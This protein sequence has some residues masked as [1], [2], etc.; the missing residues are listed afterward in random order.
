MRHMKSAISLAAAMTVAFAFYGCNGSDDT[1]SFSGNNGTTPPSTTPATPS[2][3]QAEVT[4]KW[5]TGDLHVHTIESDD[6]QNKLVDVLDQAMI[7]NNLDWTAITN[8]LRVSTRDQNGTAIVGGPLPF[9]KA[10]ADYEIP[11]VRQLQVNGSYT[12][13][14]IFSAFEWDMPTHDHM[15]VGI[16]SGTPLATATKAANQFEYYFTDR[17]AA[18]FDAADVASW[19]TSG[20]KGYTTHAD[21][22]RAV[23]WL[24]D[25]FPDTSY[26]LI[27]HPS[28]NSGKYTVA[29]YR[30]FNDTAPKVVFG[31]EGMVGNQM[32]PDR[33]GYTTAYVD[34]NL[35]NR[36]YGGVDY[37]VAQV[38]GIWDALL[39]DGR[40]FWNVGDSD[41]HFKT[42]GTNSSG[43]Y[44][45]EY[46]KTYV[47][48]DNKN[49]GIKGVLEGVR[50]GKMFSV[51]GDLINALD[52]NI[53]SGAGKGEM[54]GELKATAGETVTVTIRFKSPDRNNYQYPING[55]VNVNM[56]PVVD[57]IDLIAGDVTPRAAAGTPEYSKETNDSTKV[58]ATFTSADWKLDKDGYNTVTY[59][60]KAARN[61]YFRLRGTN[62]GMNVAGET[63]N[64]NPLP[65]Q[66]VSVTEA[67]ARFNAINARNY[68]DLWFYSNPVF[69]TVGS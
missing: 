53:A 16:F 15:N 2:T 9:S 12:T 64:G 23:A 25:N 47:W 45:G 20:T 4:G 42:I 21:A 66:K 68:N 1:S 51:F 57:H 39:G 36:V 6:A 22:V 41:H 13:K 30:E 65:D 35:K 56:R 14:L 46:A 61:Q 7:T 18:Q 17:P 10:M 29:D 34:A 44:P 69:V 60:Y 33:G 24:R 58:I 38:G 28:R 63:S 52:F 19:N 32:E 59:T 11:A 5:T 31:V 62:L 43:Y 49:T 50:S 3:P 27:N 67:D 40:R 37:V 8:H 26:A 48:I 54:G 55:G